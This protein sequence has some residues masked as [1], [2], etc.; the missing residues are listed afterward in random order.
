MAAH[1]SP[2]SCGQGSPALVPP[3]A[4]THFSLLITS[5]FSC[6]ACRTWTCRTWPTCSSWFLPWGAG[7][8]PLPA[9]RDLLDGR[10]STYDV[11]VHKLYTVSFRG[12]CARMGNTLKLP[13][14]TK[15][16]WL[17]HFPPASQAGAPCPGCPGK[18]CVAVSDGPVHVLLEGWYCVSE[19]KGIFLYSC[20]GQ[21]EW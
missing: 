17:G 16:A 19:A 13:S 20:T 8:R 21:R 12:R 3:T 11:S 4:H 2:K 14:P 1:A 15:L 5:P 7:R 18:S 6:R 10:W 9:V